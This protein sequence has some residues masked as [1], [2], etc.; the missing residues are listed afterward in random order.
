MLSRLLPGP[1]PS[2]PGDPM[3]RSTSAAAVALLL[4]TT[5]TGHTQAPAP[6]PGDPKPPA[7]GTRGNA[8]NVPYI[9]KR[10][11]KGNPVR[12]ARATGHV[13]NYTEEKVPAYT[14]PDP[15]VLA[16]GRRVTSAEV[17]TKQRR[18]EI[19]KLYQDEIYGRIPPNAPKVTWEVTETDKNAREGTAVRRRVVGKMGD[20]P[21]GPRM[22]LTIYTPVKA[23]KP[24][25]ILLSITF[26]FP[27]AKTKG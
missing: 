1:I 17:W 9:G 20:R 22:N 10:D 4:A 5:P 24:V 23:E 16:S 25:P 26:S 27:A 8:D 18:P 7:P 21:G 11:P 12:L 14:L 3:R 15:L 6:R 13:S 2:T 19:L